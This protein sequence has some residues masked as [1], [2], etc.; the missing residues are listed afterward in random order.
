MT[1]PSRGFAGAMLALPVLYALFI[2]ALV[3]VMVRGVSWSELIRVIESDAI[4]RA[5]VLSLLTST[6]AAIGAVVV[7]IPAGYVL[8]RFRFRGRAL[9]DAIFDIPIA[10]PPIVIGIALLLLFQTTPGRWFE[11]NLLQ[12]TYAIPAIVIAQFTV[13]CAFAIRTMRVAC[14]RIDPRREALARSL[15]CSR[16]Q[17][18]VRVVLPE[19]RPGIVAAWTIAW[20]RSLGEFGPVLIFAS[21][22][23]MK[24]EVMPTSIFLE[25]NVGNIAGALA[26]SII[27]LTLALGSV[28]LTRCTMGQQV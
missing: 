8:T 16:V 28:L 24:T 5:I 3:V 20:A 14:D 1:R 27:L 25:L 15:G 6:L 26:I 10:L 2:I 11:G 22:T 12:V 4:R 19:L 17:A 9:L 18:I 7:A 23:R 21:A 13:A